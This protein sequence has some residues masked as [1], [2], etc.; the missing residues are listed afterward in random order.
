MKVVV[1]EYN[2]KWAIQFQTLK[3]ELEDVLR[4]VKYLS[5]EHIGSTSVPRLAAK[6][7]IDLSVI[8]EPTDVGPAI[9]ASTSRGG[10]TYLG[11]MGIPDR[12][13]FRKRGVLPA[14]HLYVSVAGCQSIRNHLG[15]RDICRKKPE[16]RD[17]Y[18]QVK[19]ELSQR[20]WKDVDEYCEAKN[21]ILGWVLEQAGIDREERDQVRKLNTKES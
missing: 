16:V 15:V 4:G 5:I 13:A 10:Y 1:E 19:L 14:R 9:E 8:S 17:A 11:E 18:G 6:P 20:D 7:V 3:E 2:P 21:D 12:H